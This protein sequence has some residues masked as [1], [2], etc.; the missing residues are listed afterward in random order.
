MIY[1]RRKPQELDADILA[2]AKLRSSRIQ[3]YS[4]T[5]LIW[6]WEDGG[7]EDSERSLHRPS[8]FRGR[9]RTIQSVHRFSRFL[10]VGA[11]FQ[12]TMNTARTV[13]RMDRDRRGTEPR[14]LTWTSLGAPSS[15][16]FAIDCSED[17]RVFVVRPLFAVRHQCVIRGKPSVIRATSRRKEPRF[18]RI[19]S[20][21][22]SDSTMWSD[23]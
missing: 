2:N 10:V 13:A 16:S 6:S 17:V 15:S 20:T 8:G 21:C 23:M 3:R 19:F 4:D 9:G 18:Y 1:Y 7:V 12:V 22:D 5:M 14:T 11:F